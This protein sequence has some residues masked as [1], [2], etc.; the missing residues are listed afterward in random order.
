[1]VEHEIELRKIIL[2]NNVINIPASVKNILL[3]SFSYQ[4]LV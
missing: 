3:S 4:C 2:I 1:M